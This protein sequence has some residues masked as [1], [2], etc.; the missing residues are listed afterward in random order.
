VLSRSLLVQNLRIFSYFKDPV[1]PPPMSRNNISKKNLLCY[2]EAPV[3][4]GFI[5]IANVG[6]SA[7]DRGK[8]CKLDD[9]VFL[10][11]F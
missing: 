11:D 4:Q 9:P 1:G 5:P 2:S 10:S 7:R 3:Y 8:N 6:P